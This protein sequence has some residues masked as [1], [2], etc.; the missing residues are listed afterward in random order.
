MITKS[1]QG[2]NCAYTC[3]YCEQEFF[4]DLL[5]YTTLTYGIFFLI[6]IKDG[7]FGLICPKCFRTVIFKEALNNL[8]SLKEMVFNNPTNWMLGEND[9]FF[10][11]RSFPYDFHQKLIFK[12]QNVS[13]LKEEFKTDYGKIDFLDDSGSNGLLHG[14]YGSYF[15]SDYAIG[16]AIAIHWFPEDDIETLVN[17]ENETRIKIFPRYMPQDQ[18]ISEMDYFC[19]NDHLQLQFYTSMELPFEIETSS[20]FELAARKKI[21]QNFELLTVLEM[22][23]SE[24]II[25]P[26]R[27]TQKIRLWK[28]ELD[29]TPIPGDKTNAT[30]DH[31]IKVVW[32]NFNNKSIQG[33]LTKIVGDFMQEY[34]ELSQ[35]CL[36]SYNSVWNLKETYL[37]ILYSSIFNSRKRKKEK[38]RL[39]EKELKQVKAAEKSFPG[40]NIVSNDSNIGEIKTWISNTARF[41][42]NKTVLLLGERGT[43]KDLFARAIHEASNRDGGFEPFDCGSKEENVFASELF[44]HVKGAFTGAD[45]DKKGALQAANKGTIFLDEI[46]NL[47]QSMQKKLLQVLQNKSFQ[48][49][50]STEIIAV[51]SII[52]LATNKDLIRLIEEN[53]FLPDLYERFMRP[54]KIIPPLRK[55]KGDIPLLVYHFIQLFD[56]EKKSNI[57]IE[58][59]EIDAS[60]LSILERYSWPGNV[61]ELEKVI[62]DIMLNR[63]GAGNRAKIT[64][65]DILPEYF[66]GDISFSFTPAVLNKLPGN[67][68]VTDEQIIYYMKKYKGTKDFNARTA[69]KLGV[70]KKTIWLRWKKIDPK[71]K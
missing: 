65:R 62:E 5:N 25:P 36:F 30:R 20:S 16:P 31:M 13:T 9:S 68:K 56:E 19:W 53:L 8:K 2:V 26:Q 7:F 61:R 51:D 41:L 27:V 15:L 39:S 35:K 67:T 60:A 21:R 33:L 55:R 11:Y 17:I 22:Q 47:T 18:L 1:T 57:D 3:E 37:E 50:G 64:E 34:K 43:G 29:P 10:K 4:D 59:I 45:T 49:V 70:N 69:R 12:R 32:E 48:K 40:V 52:I 24:T 44:G 28:P 42:G 14:Y 6:G 38:N 23:P 66:S 63:L 54:Q 71:L 58:P 46:G